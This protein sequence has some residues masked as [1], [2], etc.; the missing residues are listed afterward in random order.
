MAGS[1]VAR[2]AIPPRPRPHLRAPGP[3]TRASAASPPIMHRVPSSR[4][5]MV[6][7][8]ARALSVQRTV[9]GGAIA[10]SLMMLLTRL[11]FIPHREFDIDELEHAHAA[12]SVGSG[13]VPYRDFFEHH[14]P[15]LYLLLAPV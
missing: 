2:S 3:P 11:W 9:A 10:L 13:S 15:A 8:P 12:W 1:A 5:P 14:G 7:A 6:L 4:G